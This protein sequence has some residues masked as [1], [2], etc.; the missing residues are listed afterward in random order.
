MNSHCELS[1]VTKAYLDTF[2]KI[3]NNMI[4][5]MTSVHLTNSI[6][7][8][9]IRQM[10]PHHL[11][12]IEMSNNILKYTTNL[13]LQGIALNIIAEQTQSIANMQAIQQQCSLMT[14]TDF[15]RSHYMD[16]FKEISETMFFEMGSAQITNGVNANFVREMIP[17]H[18]G[19]VRMSNNVLHFNICPMLKP[20]LYAIISSQ[21]KGIK[22]MQQL[23]ARLDCC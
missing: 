19:A 1:L 15:E 22:Q 2:F 13:E 3:L 21:C 11:A 7:D 17:H 8:I 23:L 14:N 20:I 9:F 4:Q 16:R 18:E 10:V 6:S 12:A 5:N